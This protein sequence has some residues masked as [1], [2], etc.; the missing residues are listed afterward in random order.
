MEILTI[1]KGASQ[2]ATTTV[3]IVSSWLDTLEVLFFTQ[4]VDC[5]HLLTLSG[6]WAA[7]YLAKLIEIV[8]LP[9]NAD[10]KFYN[11]LYNACQNDSV[12]H[13]GVAQRLLQ[14]HNRG[15]SFPCHFI[16]P[17]FS[18]TDPFLQAGQMSKLMDSVAL[19]LWAL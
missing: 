10:A 4:A 3:M 7:R 17:M 19:T 15:P 6:A 8:G 11:L 16:V 9:K 12:I 5:Y 14:D 1:A 13:Q 2:I 18:T